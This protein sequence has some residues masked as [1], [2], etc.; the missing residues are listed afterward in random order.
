FLFPHYDT[1]KKK[2]LLN[3]IE[4]VRTRSSNFTSHFSNI[5]IFDWQVFDA[6]KLEVFRV[7]TL[8]ITGFDDP[9]T[10]KISDESSA[11]L[12]SLAEALA[13]YHHDKTS[14][15]LAKYF[16]VAINYLSNH[17]DFNSFDRA[18]FITQYCDPVTYSMS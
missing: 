11:A 6:A 16:D 1:S 10:L 9:L 4:L 15:S 7:E 2:E 3:Q 5:D 17:T 12:K 8:G 13:F 18:A 14:D